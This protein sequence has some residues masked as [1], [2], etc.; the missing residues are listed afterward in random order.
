[1]MSYL[2]DF[3]ANHGL[4]VVIVFVCSAIMFALIFK[5][6]IDE[7]NIHLDGSVLLGLEPTVRKRSRLLIQQHGRIFRSPAPC[8]G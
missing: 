8:F 5:P 3:V 1:M 7:I 4:L 2:F 6:R